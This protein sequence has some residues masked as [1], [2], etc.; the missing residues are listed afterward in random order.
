M[1]VNLNSVFR[2]ELISSITNRSVRISLKTLKKNFLPVKLV[3]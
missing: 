2:P 1:K 3:K